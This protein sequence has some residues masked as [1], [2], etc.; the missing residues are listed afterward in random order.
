MNRIKLLL[1]LGAT[2]AA[3]AGA[4]CNKARSNGP[5]T[6][7]SGQALSTAMVLRVDLPPAVL[8]GDALSLEV[9][10]RNSA[11]QLLD[12][13]DK[14]TV[15]LAVNPSGAVMTGTTTRAAVNGVARFNDL[16]IAKRGQGYQLLVSSLR[17]ASVKSAPFAVTWST[18]ELEAAGT[19]SNDTAAGAE[20]ISPDVPMFGML[21]PGDVDVYRFHASAGQLL[22]VATHATRLDLGNWD[23]SLR[24]RLI[25]ADGTTEI[26]RGGA[27]GKDTPSVDTGFAGIRIPDSGDYYLACDTDRRGFLSGKYA[28]VVQLAS[29]PA[30]LQV[31]SEPPGATGKNDTLATAQALIPG[32]LHGYSDAAAPGALPS[33]DYFK[34]AIA[35]PAHVRLD[36][37]AT[38]NGSFSGDNPWNPRL[39]LQDSAGNL[40]SRNDG[41]AFVDP[42]VDF[43]VTAPGT[44][45]V[46]VASAANG[47][48]SGSTPYFLTYHSPAYAPLAETAGNTTAATAMPLGYG[49][50]VAGS[51]D[52]AGDHYFIF[53][54][55]AGDAVRL[56]VEDRSQLQGASL[57]LDGASGSDAAFL[58]ADG[59][60]ELASASLPDDPAQR[61]SNLR[62]TIL[63]RAGSYLV[64]VRSASPGSFGLRLER[65]A[66]SSRE[67]EPNNTAANGTPVDVGGVTSG[68]ISAAGG[69]D[70]F[71][72][73][74]LAG[75]LVSVSLYAADGG[76]AG[77]N[78]DLGSALLPAME[79]HDPRGNLVSAASADRKG[80]INVAESVLR[81]EA[82]V[83]ASFRAS[84]EGNYDV[85]AT[86][87]DGQGGA[88]FFYALRVWKNQ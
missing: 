19:A 61:G 23:T 8:P 4:A 30:G 88:N 80:E 39:E 71:T 6:S 2:A 27:F 64:R 69:K 16:A 33:S 24:L 66:A 55:A 5:R 79:I 72:V 82:M 65:I 60:R 81:P 68:V 14:V 15:S 31:E 32:V 48:T 1:A 22:S 49:N 84:A 21:G 45:Y 25:A 77:S 54:G 85:A 17:A 59:T 67:T 56:W 57:T 46:R 10:F 35:S 75:Q 7:S 3:L 53:V 38:S 36:L 44:Y 58:T 43:I 87:A 63:P 18:D 26:A 76:I 78:A 70:H 13:A 28:L 83:E 20:A 42:S 51:F 50:E 41:A 47:S 40:L 37:A 12:V 62:Q 86:D 74:A 29:L 11:G 52:A 9:S 73:H 34:I